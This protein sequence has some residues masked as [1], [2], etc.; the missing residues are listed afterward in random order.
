VVTFAKAADAYMAAHEA[1]WRNAKHKAQ[2]QMT[3]TKYAGPALG[4][5]PI[6]R[7]ATSDVLAALKPLWLDTPETA[8]RLRGRIESV[9][10]FAAVNGWRDGANPAR[11]RGHLAKLLPARSKVRAVKHHS[12]IAWQDLSQFL[13]VLR[14]GDSV[15]AR[16]VEMVILTAARSGEVLGACWGEIDLHAAIWT[17]PA[18]RMKARREHRVALSRSAVSLLEQMLSMRTTTRPDELVFPGKETGRPLSV[19]AMTMVLRRMNRTEITIHGFRSTFRDW[20][21]ETTGHPREVVEAALAHRTGDRVEQAYARGDLFLKRRKLMEDWS[22]FCGSSPMQTATK[23]V[24]LH[25][26]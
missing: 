2:W 20:A 16:A 3:L 23:V 15:S 1:G 5:L 19:M 12:A 10:D 24:G 14:K 22:E 13:R 18:E 7:I 4:S 25:V 21:V 9:L 26:A 8:T 6:D 17:V 11:W